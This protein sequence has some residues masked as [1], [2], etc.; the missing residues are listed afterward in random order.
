[1]SADKA[2]PGVVVTIGGKERRLIFDFWA[3]FLIE[4]Q[5]G[6]NALNG[7]MF[8]QPSVSDI[9]TLLW[10]GLQTTEKISMED[11]GHMINFKDMPVLSE[12]IKQAFDQASPKEVD[13]KKDEAG[14]GAQASVQAPTEH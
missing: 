13:A 7:E 4:K 12:A 10:A 8:T 9:L 2:V 5:T 14:A 1:M 3:F 11:L 6:K